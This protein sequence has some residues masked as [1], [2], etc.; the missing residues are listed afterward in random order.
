MNDAR[1]PESLRVAL[2]SPCYWPEVRRGT[3]RFARELA[4]GLIARGQR[5]SLIT[6]HPG[7][8]SRRREDGLP[9]LR[10]PRP[11][12][13]QLIRRGFLPYLTH[14]PLSYLALRAGT[15]DVAHALYPADAL[16]AAAWR[17]ATGLPAVLSYMGIPDSRG[18]REHRLGRRVT[19]RAIA[20]CDAVV[21]LSV[22]A[23]RALEQTLG[24]EALVIPPG[25]DLDVF[26]PA[27]ARAE[28]PTVV[29]SAAVDVPR[30]NVALLVRAMAIVRRAVPEARLVLSA[31]RSPADRAL[32]AAEQAGVVWTNLD[33]RQALARA[34][35]EAWVS[36][37][38]A[39]HEAFGLVLAEALACGTPV[40]G[41]AH[42]GIPEIIDRNAI[43]RLFEPLEPHALATALLEALE[44]AR[45]P[46]T[47]NRCRERAREFSLDRC[48]ERYL[49]LYRRLG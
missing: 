1:P 10:L 48:A 13:R 39:S 42:G 46:G 25:V 33:D 11:P 30:K 28:V 15:F 8:P 49:E 19:A 17:R 3:E 7:L 40:V 23:A 21:A 36:A 41:Y 12:Q 6:S 2:L 22:H 27:P 20:G 4:N 37:L 31:P 44:L 34:Y 14:A 43:G 38:P 32:P 5:P 24:C 18:L 16:A 29:C 45:D 9:V 26:R 47:V 35:G